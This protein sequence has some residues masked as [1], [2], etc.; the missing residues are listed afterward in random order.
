MQNYK[1]VMVKVGSRV[2]FL[3]D[4]GVGVVVSIKGNLAYVDVDGFEIPAVLSDIVEV[5]QKSENEAILKIGPDDPKPQKQQ[6][7]SAEDAGKVKISHRT[8]SAKYGRVSIA[9][10]WEDDEGID[11]LDLSAIQRNYRKRVEE[12]VAQENMKIKDEVVLAPFEIT[13]FDLKL[14]FVPIAQDGKSD[15]ESDLQMYLINDSSY[16]LYYTVSQWNSGYVVN[17][18]HGMLDANTKESVKKYT[19]QSLAQISTLH[20][21]ILPFKVS[22]YAPQR[23]ESF[24]LELHPLKFV[25]PSS[26]QENP[27]FDSSAVVFTLAESDAQVEPELLPESQVDDNSA[28]HNH[29]QMDRMLKEKQRDLSSEAKDGNK[30]NAKTARHTDD[31]NQIIDLHASEIL[32]N[33]EQMSS[34]EIL[35]AQLARFS[36]VMDGAV[37]SG[38]RN[39][40]VFIHGVGSGKLKYEMKKLLDRKYSKF[41]YQDASFA[42]YGYG[43]IMV[44]V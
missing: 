14:A 21:S 27:F 4:T 5:D 34:G 10:D 19:R 38:K 20:I 30:N 25:R 33:F 16:Q 35:N 22:S 12:S 39:K 18:A 37:K 44:F 23:V 9:N 29:K 28:K 2:K 26:Y 1:K 6:E 40:L 31:E 36:I 41:R 8:P 15:V 13:D 24:D 17:I 3:S 7:A 43:A 32:E 11:P 42:E